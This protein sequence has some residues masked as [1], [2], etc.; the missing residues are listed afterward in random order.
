[1]HA[2]SLPGSSPLTHT[3]ASETHSPAPPLLST[4]R[5]RLSRLPPS[6][7]PPGRGGGETSPE[8][9][10]EPSTPVG[11][12]CGTEEAGSAWI[13][14]LWRWLGA[15]GDSHWSPPG[16]GFHVHKGPQSRW[17]GELDP[18]CGETDVMAQGQRGVS[19]AVSRTPGPR[20]GDS[21]RRMHWHFLCSLD[22]CP[23]E[24]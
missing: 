24:S 9:T 5:P 11:R 3:P 21:R 8:P 4:L 19:G 14:E 12:R 13:P 10:R 15:S 6:P 17:L 7:R 23:L 16:L 1:M 2:Y 22:D 20:A 18:W